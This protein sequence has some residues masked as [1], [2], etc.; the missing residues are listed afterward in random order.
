VLH[1]SSTAGCGGIDPHMPYMHDRSSR[2]RVS[3]SAK[4]FVRI[5]RYRS[6]TLKFAVQQESKALTRVRSQIRAPAISSGKVG[7]ACQFNGYDERCRVPA[8]NPQKN[9]G[10]EARHSTMDACWWAATRPPPQPAGGPR[11]AGPLRE[12]ARAL[13]WPLPPTPTPS[14]PSLA[15]LGLPWRSES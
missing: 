5:I 3:P 4:P 15:V 6:T 14:R 10:G 8:T 13:P 2:P 1:S 9:Q 7:T 12:I 11:R